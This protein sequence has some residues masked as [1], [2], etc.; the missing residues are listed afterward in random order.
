MCNSIATNVITTSYLSPSYK[1]L[2]SSTLIPCNYAQNVVAAIIRNQVVP[3]VIELVTIQ[4]N[5]RVTVSI[6]TMIQLKNEP[7][8]WNPPATE[9]VKHVSSLLLIYLWL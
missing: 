9:R 7:M 4:V 6:C 5:D 2:C 8:D 3:S 1:C